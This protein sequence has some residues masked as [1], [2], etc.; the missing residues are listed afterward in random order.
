M[1]RAVLVSAIDL[2][3]ELH[4]TVLFRHNVERLTATAASDVRRH[5]A[6]GRVDVIV[7]DSAICGASGL[8]AALR[9]DPLTRPTAIVAL[10]RSEFGLGQLDILQ[11]GANAI[12]PL[13]PGADWDDR[14]MRL[15]NVPMR[16]LTHLP[17]ELVIE[18]GLRGGRRAGGRLLNLS[19]H[20][21]LLEC[22]GDDRDRRRPPARVRAAGRPRACVR[23]G[24]RR[25]RGP[26]AALRRGAD[27]HR[28]RR[29]RPHQALRRVLG[30]LKAR[31]YNPDQARP[32]ARRPPS[33]KER[34]E[35][36]HASR[37]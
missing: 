22:G 2:S 11:A 6:Q 28:G 33:P 25:A 18:G 13:P 9:Q 32:P 29:P 19:V 20:G 10:G 7:V 31:R 37:G 26:A 21:L 4:A 36:S 35:R 3:R 30:G 5:A 23:H 8:V 27:A 17:V 1:I 16:K 14:L 15:L 24:H 12:L 34:H